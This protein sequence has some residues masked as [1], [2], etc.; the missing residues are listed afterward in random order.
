MM[1]RSVALADA[2]SRNLESAEI[3]WLCRPVAWA[4]LGRAVVSTFKRIDLSRDTSVCS[5][6]VIRSPDDEEF[7]DAKKGGEWEVI[8]REVWQQERRHGAS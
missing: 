4:G 1:E 5:L 7:V 8:S 3:L 2:A 6:L